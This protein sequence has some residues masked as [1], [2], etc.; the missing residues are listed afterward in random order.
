MVTEISIGSV[1]LALHMHI[2]NVFA[3]C[4][5]PSCS[6]PELWRLD[7]SAC[8]LEENEYGCR[9]VIQ[10]ESN[11]AKFTADMLRSNNHQNVH[12]WT[13]SWKSSIE[14]FRLRKCALYVITSVTSI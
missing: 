10:H 3:T 5:P 11:L 14:G 1:S 2:N 6:H 4:E 8:E 12:A 13:L 7:E 9:S